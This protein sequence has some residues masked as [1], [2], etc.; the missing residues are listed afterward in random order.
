GVGLALKAVDEIEELVKDLE[1]KGKMSEI[2]GKK[3]LNDL[4]QKYDE[5]QSKLE[6][7]VEST[8]KEF[9]KKVNVVTSDDLG[10]LKKEIRELK[11]ANISSAEEL[12]ELRKEIMGLKEALSR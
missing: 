6:A 2:D 4:R 3:F 12:N 10:G 9:F 5:A 11:K 8:G 7:K 1:K